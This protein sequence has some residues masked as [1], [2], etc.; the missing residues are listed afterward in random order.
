MTHL[1]IG[2]DGSHAAEVALEWGLAEAARR[3][4]AVQLVSVWSTPVTAPGPASAIAIPAMVISARTAARRTAERA[5]KL[6]AD[7]GVQASTEVLDGDPAEVLIRLSAAADQLVVGARGRSA[8]TRTLL[9][10]VSTAAVRH[11]AGPVTVVRRSPSPRHHRIV[12][13]V[14]GS[15]DSVSALRRALLEATAAGAELLVVTAWSRGDP[16]LIGE[17][18]GIRIP[19][20][21][22]LRTLADV[23]ARDVMSRTGADSASI[24]VRLS[25]RYGAAAHVLRRESMHADL[26]VVGT[27]G[28]GALDRLLFGST[29]SAVLHH[30]SC[31][32]Q[33]VPHR[34]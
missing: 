6:A 7:A 20:D 11:A 10:S 1:T 29:S 24:P 14:D 27:H 30:A 4:L 34:T 17:F 9:G 16:D 33:V 3:S 28:W 22:D 25:V 15:E 5:A 8:V 13:G 26:V 18:A 2:V 21:E 31:P 12:V 32:V 19:L 23:R